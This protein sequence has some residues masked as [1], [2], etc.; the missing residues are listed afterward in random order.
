MSCA[1]LD[2]ISASDY[3]NDD[4]AADDDND[5]Y[6]LRFETSRGIRKCGLLR[7]CS[8]FLRIRKISLWLAPHVA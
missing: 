4:D 6:E 2:G 1:T 5:D 7:F 8:L 3:Y